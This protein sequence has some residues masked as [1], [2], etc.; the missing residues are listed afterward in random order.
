M[1]MQDKNMTP[2][3][4][5]PPW[6]ACP[7]IERYSIGWRMGY[8]EDY[9]GQFFNWLNA[10]SKEKQTEY[11][12][13]FP[14]PVTWKGW[15]ENV[16]TVEELVHGE[17]SIPLWRKLGAPKYTRT[18]LQQENAR[19]TQHEFCLFWGGQPAKDGS[20]HKSCLSQWWIGDFWSIAHNYCCMEQFMMAQKAELFGDEEI[21]QQ[22]LE[23]HDPRQM[24]TLGRNIR[25]FDQALWDRAKYSIVLN[26]NWCKFSQNRDLRDFLLSTGDKVLAEASLYDAIW[27]IRLSTDSPDA[28]NPHKWQGENLLGFAL[29]EVRDELR[30]IT[31]NGSLCDWS[32]VK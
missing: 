14:E 11:Q 24:K 8:G 18:Q 23:S 20:I 27:G 6:L 15:W 26:G 31:Q 28:Q 2:S 25:N 21:R 9:I 7:E 12:T 16:D 32:V 4:M 10:L 13:L 17:F 29:M 30:R 19:G 22:I 5:P 3:L 1:K